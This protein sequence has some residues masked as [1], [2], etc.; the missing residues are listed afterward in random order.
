MFKETLET[1]GL[2][3]EEA[4]IYDILLLKGASGAGG[5]LEKTDIKRGLLYKILER[6]VGK[7]LVEEKT[8]RGRTVFSAAPPDE[9]LKAADAAEQ[10][11][12]RKRKAIEAALPE[13]KAKFNLAHERPFIRFYEGVDGLRQLY[14]EKL[15]PTASKEFRFIRP[16]QAGVYRDVFGKWFGHFLA[17]RAEMGIKTYAI[18]PDDPDANHDPKIDKERGVTR[19]WIRPEDYASHV[20]VNTHGDRTELISYGKEIFAVAI[21][22]AYIARAIRDL[23]VLAD[24]GAKTIEVK[25][26]HG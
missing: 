11:A 12:I 25:H 5:I 16:L 26:D 18:T 13:M 14:E 8:V 23:L 7:G 19:T 6:L 22:D 1:L 17:K 15:A 2:T 24:R 20:E 10:E 4:E 3:H 21:E 9:L